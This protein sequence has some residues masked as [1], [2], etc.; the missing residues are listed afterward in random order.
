[1]IHHLEHHE[2]DRERWDTC[3]RRSFNG[4]IYA[5]SWYLDIVAPGWEALIAD[6]YSV[7]MPLP[8]GR[9]FGISY[10]YTPYFIQQL[11]VF[12]IKKLVAEDVQQFLKS[13]P[14]SYRYI[15]INFNTFNKIVKSDSYTLHTHLTHELDL[16]KSSDQL[17]TDYSENTRRN[18]RKALKQNL[19]FTNQASREEIITLFRKNRGRAVRVWGEAEYDILRKLLQALDGRGR[20]HVRGVSNQEGKLLAGAFFI[21][22]NGKVIFLFSGLSEEGR[23][24]GAMFALIDRFIVENAHKNLILDFEGSDDLQLARFYKSFGA[25]ECVYLQVKSNQLPW[26]IRWFKN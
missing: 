10:L 9:K 24:K 6:D 12:S 15:E 25:K 18:I 26:P 22:A 14:D 4:I 5:Y 1:M 16:I 21:D 11:G 3:I 13:I 23:E 20:L 2:I 17:Q 8:K 7:V 19:V